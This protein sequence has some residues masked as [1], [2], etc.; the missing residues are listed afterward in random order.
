MIKFHYYLIFS[1]I[2]FIFLTNNSYGQNN[3][4]LTIEQA[5]EIVSQKEYQ[6]FNY[7]P[8]DP[9]V[10]LRMATI[11]WQGE[12]TPQKADI[13][14][15]LMAL[16]GNEL[17]TYQKLC[18]SKFLLDLN[19]E[20]AKT[21]IEK[22]LANSNKSI[23]NN[24]IAIIRLHVNRNPER[25]WGI[26]KLI[27]FLQNGKSR[28]WQKSDG[29]GIDGSSVFNNVCYDLGSMKYKPALDIMIKLTKQYPDAY[30]PA[31]A[32]REIG[33]LRAVPI[34]IDTLE[35]KDGNRQRLRPSQ[36]EA[37]AKLKAKDAVPILL[38]Y[39]QDDHVIS[40][41]GEIKDERAIKPLQDIIANEKKFPYVQLEAKL[42]LVK[43]QSD[44]LGL[45]LIELLGKEKNNYKKSDI[46]REL[47]KIQEKRA[48][49]IIINQANHA[50][51][52]MF[53][54]TCVTTLGNI[55]GNEAIG[56]LIELFEGKF[57]ELECSKVC[58]TEKDYFKSI[59]LA[60]STATEMNYGSNKQAWKEWFKN[61]Y[62]K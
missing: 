20:D 16:Q 33:D 32:L 11:H 31:C 27:E 1:F 57:V 47:Q 9:E 30:G 58:L 43:I 56:G 3:K 7:G 53:K 29:Q 14:Q 46:I 26:S 59:G 21:F 40:A 4:I 12:Y 62:P 52:Q 6:G 15:L 24:A 45:S 37:L 10:A 48:V 44:D 2:T 41:L 5:L 22:Q 23:F 25:A 17:D 50:P 39:L 60:L 61:N 51:S 36:V 34:L 13:P 49:E 54:L 42:A 55:G 35:V 19:V 28:P 18:V 8:G 38:K